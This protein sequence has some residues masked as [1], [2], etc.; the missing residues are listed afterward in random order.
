[1]ITK[2]IKQILFSRTILTTQFIDTQLVHL[3][4]KLIIII[5]ILNYNICYEQ[6]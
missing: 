2:K 5:T 3:I 4:T 6:I 1:M